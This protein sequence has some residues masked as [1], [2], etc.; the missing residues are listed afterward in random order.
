MIKEKYK[1]LCSSCHIGEIFTIGQMEQLKMPD[2]RISFEKSKST[3]DILSMIADFGKGSVSGDGP[4]Y[5]RNYWEIEYLLENSKLWLDSPSNES[6]YSG[7]E[8][9][10]LWD[11][12]LFNPEKELG[13]RFH[14]QRVF[15]KLGLA[16]GKAGKLRFTPYTGEFFYDNVAV[17]CPYNP[18]NLVALWCYAISGELEDEIR[19]L[20]KKIAV[21]AGTFIKIPFDLD[22]WT[23]V[24]EEKYPHCLPNPYSDDPTQW[25]FH[26]HP[27]GSVIW[28]EEN[29]WTAHGPLRTDPTVL[30]IAVARL[31]GYRWPAELDPD[32]ELSDKQREWVKR[33][34]TLLPLPLVDE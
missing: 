10:I 24:A 3:S 30:Q 19:K 14:G 9:V 8:S 2:F 17:I 25:I 29:K 32:M 1:K 21:T 27:C 7:R 18:S 26:G 20:D 34:E 5:I 31:L 15:G 4:H 13:F 22:H 28:D 6:I 12:G 16:I 33:C 11:N 23:K